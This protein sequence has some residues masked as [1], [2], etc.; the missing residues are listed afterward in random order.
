MHSLCSV[1]VSYT[2]GG[3]VQDIYMCAR[4][5]REF[6]S[7]LS[8]SHLRGV[9]ICAHMASMSSLEILVSH[10]ASREELIDVNTESRMGICFRFNFFVCLSSGSNTCQRVIKSMCGRVCIS[11][12]RSSCTDSSQ[13]TFTLCWR[14]GGR[15]SF[16]VPTVTGCVCHLLQYRLWTSVPSHWS[17]RQ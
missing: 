8:T 6:A 12:A 17:A 15:P 11:A 1:Q 4:I 3:S 14:W 2:I 16:S 7:E 10:S 13:V 5:V 9:Q